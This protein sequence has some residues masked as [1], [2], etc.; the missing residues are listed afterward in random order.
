LNFYPKS[1]RFIDRGLARELTL[2]IRSRA[3]S[4][5]VFVNESP[6]AVAMTVAECALDMVQL[7]GDETLSWLDEAKKF[8]ELQG[9]PILRAISW[10]GVTEPEDETRAQAWS[11]Q[12]T[13]VGLLVD[14]YDPIQRGGTGKT[15]RW[16]LLSPRP[17]AFANKPFLLAGGLSI[18]NLEMAIQTTSPDGIDLAS[19]IESEP[20]IKDKALMSS[21]VAIAKRTFVRI[22]RQ[23]F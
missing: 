21:I 2:T 13:V 14:A 3:I 23:P 5:G 19:G 20:G 17:Q 10:R 4:V 15:A 8:P 16:D 12:E 6:Y 22:A 1:P 7:H 18:A 11:S 9:I